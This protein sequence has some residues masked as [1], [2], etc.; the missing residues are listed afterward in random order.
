MRIADKG[1]LLLPQALLDFFFLNWRWNICSALKVFDWRTV[2]RV[3][4]EYLTC[5]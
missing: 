3:Q 5:C 4:V 2:D 1:K